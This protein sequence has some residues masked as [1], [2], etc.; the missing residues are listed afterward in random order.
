MNSLLNYN[1]D[2][3]ETKPTVKVIKRKVDV[4]KLMSGSSPK[5]KVHRS[6]SQSPKK[7][8]PL[9]TRNSDDNFLNLPAPKNKMNSSLLPGSLFFTN[10]K[11]KMR[12]KTRELKNQAENNAE[13]EGYD[14][15]NESLNANNELAETLDS[16]QNKQNNIEESSISKKGSKNKS[17]I[18]DSNE[19]EEQNMDPKENKKIENNDDF[20]QHILSRT[21]QRDF[22]EGTEAIK[23]ING[24]ELR[25]FDWQKYAL[26]QKHK[27]D[28][29]GSLNLKN[30]TKNQK[31]KNQL[32]YIA[33]E[34]I[35]KQ[36]ELDH[37]KSEARVNHHVTQRKYGW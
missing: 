37:R 11:E 3:E 27:K 14:E 13:L 31:T 23:E 24:S 36:D 2:E 30:P 1:S 28:A 35:S 34:A 4:A 29:E 22:K 6:P 21:E 15:I 5:K 7:E 26:A 33:F 9:Q 20:M 17:D 25:D 10:N 19:E 16:N 18:E 8:N 32:T 12:Q